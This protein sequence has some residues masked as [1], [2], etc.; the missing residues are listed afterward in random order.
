[1]GSQ[2][3]DEDEDYKKETIKNIQEWGWIRY[4][5]TQMGKENVVH[6]HNGVLLSHKE[7]NHAICRKLDEPEIMLS[8]IS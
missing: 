6:G 3:S 5:S 4:P 7:G 1:M 2:G 8:K